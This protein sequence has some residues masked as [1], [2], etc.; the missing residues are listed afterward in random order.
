[1]SDLL[2]K[3][4]SKVRVITYGYDSH[5]N[6]FFSAAANQ[7]HIYQHGRSLLNGLE[8]IRRKNP[9]RPTIFLVHSLGGIILKDIEIRA[10]DR[11]LR[12]IYVSTFAIIFFGTPHRGSGSASWGLMAKN[13]A[14][15]AGF[16]ANDRILRD[17]KVDSAILEDLREEFNRMLEDKAFNIV[18][19]MSS[20]L[21]SRAERKDFI[22]SNH[23]DMC[24][25][26]G[27]EDDEYV[28]V[29]GVLL[30]CVDDIILRSLAAEEENRR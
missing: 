15:A 9:M 29:A 11:D 30:R 17:L 14:V 18:D 28:K 27:K 20:V 13:A 24:R 12:N 23:V 4:F 1:P 19:D 26:R 22:N 3:D 6:R 25:F 21:D 2:A 16:D 5:V 7:N 10:D 8:T